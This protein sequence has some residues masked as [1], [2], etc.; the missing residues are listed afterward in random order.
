MSIFAD[1]GIGS[2]PTNTACLIEAARRYE[3]PVEIMVGVLGQEGGRVGTISK[4]VD[5]TVDVGPMQINSRWWGTFRG[6]MTPQQI[7]YDAC[8]SFHAGA[9]ILK[10]NIIEAGDFWKGVGNYHSK[11][12]AL[13]V[14]YQVL[15]WKKIEEA[16][17]LRPEMIRTLRYYE[18]AASQ[19]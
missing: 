15:V 12:P 2:D 11:S 7:T 4:N 3:L 5:G 8:M 6:Y 19:P 18:Q 13:N 1:L 17:R 10:K 16:R 14:S 9:W